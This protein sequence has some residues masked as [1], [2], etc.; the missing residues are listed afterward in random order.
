MKESGKKV[1][2]DSTLENTSKN[3][4]ETEVLKITSNDSVN[5][6]VKPTVED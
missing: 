5:N 2:L 6:E 3:G 1:V 4:I